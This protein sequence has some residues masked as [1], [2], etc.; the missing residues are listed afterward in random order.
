MEE[1]FYTVQGATRILR[2]TERTVRSRLERD[3]REEIV[4]IP[5]QDGTVAH[6]PLSALAEAFTNSMDRL[7]AGEEMGRGTSRG[8]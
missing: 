6:F 2:T 1:D 4:E 5:Q 3:S 7:G 8:A